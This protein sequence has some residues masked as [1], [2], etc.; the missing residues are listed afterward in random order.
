MAIKIEHKPSR[1]SERFAIVFALLLC[2]LLV[3]LTLWKESEIF[4]LAIGGYPI[5]QRR[6]VELLYYPY[7]LFTL[8]ALLALSWSAILR[9]I[10][11]L[12]VKRVWLLLLFA[13]VVFGSC[14][15]LLFANNLLNYI[16]GRPIHYHDWEAIKQE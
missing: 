13:W 10:T 4:W 12:Q 5:W 11:Q 9:L 15:G 16:Q 6:L 3:R 7:M 8:L 2:A 1:W 14:L